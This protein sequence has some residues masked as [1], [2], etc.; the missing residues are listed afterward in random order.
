MDNLIFLF[1]T[2]KQAEEALAVYGYG[3]DDRFGDVALTFFGLMED[4]ALKLTAGI[5]DCDALL[6]ACYS[7]PE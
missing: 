2:I 1:P 6:G 5:R 3:A 7:S 4:E